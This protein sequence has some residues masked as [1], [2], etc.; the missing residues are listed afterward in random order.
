[1]KQSRK[2]VS[3]RLFKKLS[4]LR[5][6]LSNEEREILDG[7]IVVEEVS[8]HKLSFKKATTRTTAR[9]ARA[10]Q[11]NAHRLSLAKVG[12]KATAKQ[13]AKVQEVN[14][15]RLSLAKVGAKATAKQT[16]KQAEVNAHRLSTAKVAAKST[17][18]IAAKTA[19]KVARQSSLQVEFDPITEEYKIQK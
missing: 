8:A 15:H 5:A 1:M 13:T 4:A 17:A 2:Q 16:A 14:A 6:T 9:T 7:L 18:K 10:A 19:A 3:T 12:A 11:V